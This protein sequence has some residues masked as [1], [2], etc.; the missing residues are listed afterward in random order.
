VRVWRFDDGL[1]YLSYGVAVEVFMIEGR[2]KDGGGW[3]G[4][5]GVL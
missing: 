1:Y 4:E 3:R 5:E 2:R